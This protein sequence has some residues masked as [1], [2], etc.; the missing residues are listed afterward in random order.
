MNEMR[1]FLERCLQHEFSVERARLQKSS[2]YKE[3]W[4]ANLSHYLLVNNNGPAW[5]EIFG[6]IQQDDVEK[7]ARIQVV[8]IH[9]GTLLIHPEFGTTARFAVGIMDP[10]NSMGGYHRRIYVAP[11]DDGLR[12]VS[13]DSFCGRCKCTGIR[14]GAACPRCDGTGWKYYTGYKHPKLGAPTKVERYS[15]PTDE[16]YLPAHERDD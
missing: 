16:R 1:E 2:S 8:P 7:L 11:T 10:Q 15:P 14:D 4:E 5:L 3:L 6:D 9:K 13:L 12:I